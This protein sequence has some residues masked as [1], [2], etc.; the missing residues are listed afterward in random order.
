MR[1]YVELLQSIGSASKNAPRAAALTVVQILRHFPPGEAQRLLADAGPLFSLAQKQWHRLHS[2]LLSGHS[3]WEAANLA[4]MLRLL[5]SAPPTAVA[6]LGCG[7]SLLNEA[8]QLRTAG[9]Q[10]GDGATLV[11]VDLVECTSEE[12]RGV[13]FRHAS[14][15]NTGLTDSSVQLVQIWMYDRGT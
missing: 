10:I 7:D 5:Q 1:Q 15:A 2:T 13:F 3:S 14:S 6:S 11:G 12:G 8:A 4:H 9:V